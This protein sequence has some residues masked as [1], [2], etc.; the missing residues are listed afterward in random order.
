MFHISLQFLCIHII[1]FF[2][3]IELQFEMA[4]LTLVNISIH[5]IAVFMVNCLLENGDISN[6]K[7]KQTTLQN[8]LVS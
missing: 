5:F 8:C 6:D 1:N 4:N 2:S 7:S 3:D